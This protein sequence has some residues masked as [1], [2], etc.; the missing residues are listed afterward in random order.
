MKQY[1]S[2]ISF[3]IALLI[4]VHHYIS[5]RN[6]CNMSFQDKIFQ[7]SDIQNHETWVLFFIGIAVGRA[8]VSSQK[9]I[10]KSITK[11]R[12]NH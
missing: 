11:L 5:H 2:I 10:D 8:F 9:W 7:L 3:F 12:T 1:Q 6:D 4:V